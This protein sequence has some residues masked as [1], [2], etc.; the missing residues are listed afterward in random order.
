VIEEGGIL[1]NR[2]G[3]GAHAF[4]A[5]AVF[6]IKGTPYIVNSNIGE[7]RFVRPLLDIGEIERSDDPEDHRDYVLLRES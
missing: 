1:T 2:I 5:F 7:G 4:H 6:N 3:S